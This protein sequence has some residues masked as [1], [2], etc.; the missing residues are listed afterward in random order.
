[1]KSLIEKIL[2]FLN[3]TIIVEGKNDALALKTLGFKKIFILHSPNSSI[4]NS[5]EKIL[6][7]IT[8]GEV[9]C[10]LTD[11]DSKGKQLFSQVKKT[12]QIHGIKTDSSLRKLLASEGISH[13]EGIS[14]FLENNN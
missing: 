2:E 6:P 10:I 7:K 8:K 12:L 5:I 11:S 9:V 3:H 13:V 14:K 1:M 4:N